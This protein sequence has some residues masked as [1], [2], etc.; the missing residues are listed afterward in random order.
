MGHE[1]IHVE[2]ALLDYLL[3]CVM[4]GIHGSDILQIVWFSQ[5]K[6]MSLDKF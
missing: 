5:L 3:P 4:L 1:P 6:S 2:D